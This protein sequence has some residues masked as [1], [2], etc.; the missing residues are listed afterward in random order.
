MLGSAGLK[1]SGMRG[2]PECWMANIQQRDLSPA[3]LATVPGGSSS[4][5]GVS[6]FTFPCS[7]I[8]DRIRQVKVF[9]IE[10]ISNIESSF[11]VP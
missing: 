2:R 6:N 10:P 1:L 11:A 8:C 3:G 4:R 9:V 7:T 5:T